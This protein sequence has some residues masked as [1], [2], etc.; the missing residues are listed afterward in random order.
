VEI[1]LNPNQVIG[2]NESHPHLYLVQSMLL[3]LSQAYGSIPEPP[4]SGILDIATVESIS[5]FQQ[6][7]DLPVTG[8][9]DKITWKHL[10][11]QYPMAVNLLTSTA[12]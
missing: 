7:S 1:I 9:L 12:V 6:L 2:K 4:L 10:A 11:L 8:R 3:I 5:M